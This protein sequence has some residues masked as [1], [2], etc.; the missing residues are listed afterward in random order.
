MDY[1]KI[2]RIAIIGSP[3]SGKSTMAK[4]LGEITGIEY[5]HLD[6]YYHNANWVPKPKEEFR[7]IVSELASKDEWIMDGNYRGTLDLRVN[8]ADLVIFLNYSS[9]FSI[10]RIYKRIF[11]SKLGRV[12]RTDIPEDC[13]DGWFPKEFIMWT[14]NYNKNILPDTYR[15]LSELKINESS[16]KVFK[17]V[18]DTEIF[19]NEFKKHY[20]S[21]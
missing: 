1:K 12:K 18:R 13:H 17:R 11:K 7:N 21:K 4:K 10:Y 3:G 8:R 16:L 6:K 20:E 19:L 5:H 2:K 14:W 15:I 9:V